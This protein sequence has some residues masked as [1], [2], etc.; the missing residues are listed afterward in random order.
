MKW[1]DGRLLRMLWFGRAFPSLPNSNTRDCW[2]EPCIPNLK[3]LE[4]HESV[5]LCPFE[6][7]Q[8]GSFQGDDILDVFLKSK[9]STA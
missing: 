4:C 2:H 3:V 1:R 7:G 6:G 5:N 9:V 8:F